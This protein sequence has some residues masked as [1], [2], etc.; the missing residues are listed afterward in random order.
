MQT[1]TLNNEQMVHMM[2][3]ITDCAKFVFCRMKDLL[4]QNLIEHNIFEPVQA[5]FSPIQAITQIKNIIQNSM[6][7]FSD[8]NVTLSFDI[9]PDKMLIGDAD[10]LQQVLMNV[11][12]NA[13]KFVPQKGGRIQIHASLIESWM[14]YP[15]EEPGSDKVTI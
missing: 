1:H 8:V 3:N 6:R 11:L 5:L 12:S 4:D 14:I 7:Y 2:H 15:E 10:R 13:R 9:D